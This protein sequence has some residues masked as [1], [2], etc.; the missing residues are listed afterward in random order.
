MA[1]F[2]LDGEKVCSTG[3]EH[4]G[5]CSQVA[6]MGI[7]TIR[8]MTERTRKY[9]MTTSQQLYW[10]I[11]STLTFKI[12]EVRSHWKLFSEGGTRS[13]L[14]RMNNVKLGKAWE[15]KTLKQR[16]SKRLYIMM[17]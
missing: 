5:A 11:L 10:S 6:G 1:K 8:G 14:Q 2:L 12:Q 17:S 4:C 9:I 15:E 16:Q 3:G 13:K 7:C